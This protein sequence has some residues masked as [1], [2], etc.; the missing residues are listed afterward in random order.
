MLG[1]VI[2][3]PLP[4]RAYIQAAARSAEAKMAKK[5]KKRRAW[6]AT[7]IRKLK[8]VAKKKTASARMAKKLRRPG[9]AVPHHSDDVLTSPAKS[10]TTAADWARAFGLE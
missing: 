3:C 10:S 2:N 4:V 5:A 8:S 6:T 7:E 9:G 1:N